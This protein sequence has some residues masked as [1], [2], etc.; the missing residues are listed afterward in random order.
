[1]CT[2]TCP[3]TC[4]RTHSRHVIVYIVSLCSSFSFLHHHSIPFKPF[5]PSLPRFLPTYLPRIH[6]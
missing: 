2:D 3:N 4:I 6:H 5:I 1:M